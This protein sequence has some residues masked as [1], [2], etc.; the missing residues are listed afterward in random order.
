MATRRFLPLLACALTSFGSAQSRLSAI[1]AAHVY[2]KLNNCGPVTARMVLASYGDTVTQFQAADAMKDGPSD[3]N[4]SVD[5]MARYLGGFGLRTVHRWAGTPG[6][7]RALLAAGFPVILHQQMK[8]TDDIGHY[9]V[10][11]AAG[12][13]AVTFA[14]SYLGPKL[15][16]GDADLQTLWRPYNGEYLVAYQPGREA[17]LAAVLG[18]DWQGRHNL[19]HLER[20]TRARVRADP[21]DTYAWWGLGVARA[22]LG[23]PNGAADA[24]YQA[25]ELGLSNKQ[26]WYQQDALAAWNRIGRYDLTLRVAGR[27]LKSYPDSKELEALY[28]RALQGSKPG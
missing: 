9:R 24:F 27:A 12:P 22:A 10:A 19:L 5:E 17:E 11:Y 28:K 3:R 23:A 7:L 21:Q 6:Q 15:R 13:D 4:V 25:Q 18:D 1:P 14:D 20:E 26:Y 2:Q 8:L 16:L